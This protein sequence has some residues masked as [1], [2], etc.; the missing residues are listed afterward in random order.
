MPRA[1]RAAVLLALASSFAAS[2]PGRAGQSAPESPPAKDASKPKKDRLARPW[3]TS[4]ELQVAQ[5]SAEARPLFAT[6]EPLS[7]T[8]SADFKAIGKDR[9]VDSPKRFPGTLTVPGASGQPVAIPVQLGTRGNLRLRPKVCAFPPLRVKF[10][11]DAARGT[12]FEGQGTLKLVTHCQNTGEFD[13]FVLGESLAYRIA[14]VL[15]PFSFRARLARA[16]YLSAENGKQVAE[17]WAI[18]VEDEDDVARRMQG[19]IAPLKKQMFHNLDRP[20][21]LRMTVFEALIGNTDFSVYALHNVRLVQDRQ[22]V[23]RPVP[24]DLD[25]SGLVSPPYAAPDPRLG[26]QTVRDRRYRGPCLPVAELEPTLAEFRAK[27]AEILGLYDAETRL[28]REHR[29]AAK[30]Y[31]EDFFDILDSERRTKLLFVDRCRAASGV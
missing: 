15:T 14:N 28:T 4:E 6:K 19:R 20:T 23:L 11:K 12:A 17:R 29:N 27:K 22:G 31:L 5:A 2:A 7:F 26:L 30:S 1:W 3:P 18:F 21:L 10:S 24:Y 9:Q 16:S 25:S 13:Q 8:L